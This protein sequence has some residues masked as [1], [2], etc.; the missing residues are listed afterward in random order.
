MLVRA[1]PPRIRDA[2]LK[3]LQNKDIGGSLSSMKMFLTL[4]NHAAPGEAV[5]VSKKGMEQVEFRVYSGNHTKNN[6]TQYPGLRQCAKRH[7]TA[8]QDNP[9]G[10]VVQE[11]VSCIHHVIKINGIKWKVGQVCEYIG[12][13]NAGA[14]PL[15]VGRIES[16]IV[17]E[18]TVGGQN[19]KQ[20]VFVH[21]GRFAHESL[22]S[23]GPR[24]CTHYRVRLTKCKK[25]VTFV[26]VSAMASLLCSVP[27][28]RAPEGVHMLPPL[29]GEPA[30]PTGYMYLVPVARAFETVAF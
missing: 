12:S 18:Y 30:C 22:A 16:F 4:F 21:L 29:E 2:L 1:T 19:A 28:N 6:I 15:R 26:H 3:R 8:S 7:L 17:V 27:D 5:L 9:V 24:S 13:S 20:T 23:V 11:K 25:R 10:V 14:Q